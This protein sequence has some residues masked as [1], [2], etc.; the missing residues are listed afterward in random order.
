MDM[1]LNCANVF[2]RTKAATIVA[3]TS[4]GSHSALFGSPWK[5]GECGQ[6]FTHFKMHSATLPV[7]HNAIYQISPFPKAAQKTEPSARSR[8][9]NTWKNAS[10]TYD[11]RINMSDLAS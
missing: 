8:N 10:F 3:P 7:I 11:Q 9:V 5:L 1:K 4:G 2:P 6:L